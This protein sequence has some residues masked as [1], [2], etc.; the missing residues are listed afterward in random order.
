MLNSRPFNV[1]LYNPQLEKAALEHPKELPS[2]EV[3]EYVYIYIYKS[4]EQ[5]T[6]YH[7]LGSAGLTAKQCWTW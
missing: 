4:T 1:Q 7:R 6:L 5:I 3:A 2:H